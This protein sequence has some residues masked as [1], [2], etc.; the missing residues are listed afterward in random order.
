MPF[1]VFALF[2]HIFQVV[3]CEKFVLFK[4]LLFEALKYR[5]ADVWLRLEGIQLRPPGLPG[6]A[7]INIA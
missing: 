2:L 7:H 1:Y 3:N 4:N 6:H 5:H